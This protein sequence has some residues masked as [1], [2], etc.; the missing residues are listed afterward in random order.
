MVTPDIRDDLGTTRG[1]TGWVI[2]GYFPV[3]AESF[4]LCGRVTDLYS[5][6]RVF[7]L[8]LLVFATARR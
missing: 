3:F 8:G 2:T 6:R 5:L 1:R 4:P 7:A